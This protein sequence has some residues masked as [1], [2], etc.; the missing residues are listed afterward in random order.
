MTDFFSLPFCLLK[1]TSLGMKKVYLT[2]GG[3]TS[4]AIVSSWTVR[5][6][7]SC[8]KLCSL[9]RVVMEPLY[10]RMVP[11]MRM[12]CSMAE[13]AKSPF[14]RYLPSRVFRAR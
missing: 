8:R 12:S 5:G 6:S 11:L 3:K 13:M 10:F 2:F 4:L 7:G 1:G 9:S 14:S